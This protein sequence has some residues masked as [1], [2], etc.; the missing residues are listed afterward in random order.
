MAGAVRRFLPQFALAVWVL[1]SCAAGCGG[2]YSETG[3]YRPGAE[4]GEPV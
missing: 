2:D 1:A 4:R 3:A